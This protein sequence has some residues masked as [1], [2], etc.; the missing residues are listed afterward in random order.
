M[1]LIPDRMALMRKLVALTFAAFAAV[2]ALAMPASA[3]T[4]PTNCYDVEAISGQ[5]FDCEGS[6][7]IPARNVGG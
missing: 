4:H 5:D 3:H 2:I 6:G 1:A 7:K